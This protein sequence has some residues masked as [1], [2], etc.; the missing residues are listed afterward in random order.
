MVALIRNWNWSKIFGWGLVV[1]QTAA[2]IAYACQRNW[3][4]AFYWLL[5]ALIAVDL[6]L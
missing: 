4:L 1:N 5:A 6:T 2:A 3:K